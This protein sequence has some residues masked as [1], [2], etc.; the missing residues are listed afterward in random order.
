MKSLIYEAFGENS[1]ALLGPTGVSALNINGSTIHSKLHI[2]PKTKKML[3]LQAGALHDFRRKFEKTLFVLID[4]YSMIGCA[5]LDKIEK[6]LR[7]A[8]DKKNEPYGG[9]FLYFFGDVQQLAPVGD[10]PVYS[11]NQESPDYING[12]LLYNNIDSSIVLSQVQRQNNADFQDLLHNVSTGAVTKKDYKLLKRRFVTSVSASEKQSFDNVIHLYSTRKEVY[13]HN[14]DKLENLKD[15]VTGSPVPVAKIPAL[16]NCE[17]AAHATENEADGLKSVLYLAVGAKVMLKANL[18]TEQACIC[19]TSN[20]YSTPPIH[21]NYINV[22]LQGL[23]NGAIGQIVDI[24]YDKDSSPGEDP[25]SAIVC[26]LPSYKGPYLN[27]A[28]K[29]VV[30]QPITKSWKDKKGQDCTR[31]QFPLV[32]SYACTI[33]KSQGLTLEKVI[34]KTPNNDYKFQYALKVFIQHHPS[35]SFLL[36]PFRLS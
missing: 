8:L 17:A 30:I 33:H 35:M 28:D 5:M 11:N 31:I 13:D 12:K 27:E 26:Q 29:T 1:F 9:L 21:S 3:P 36:P 19:C 16:H 32:L 24:L 2:Q 25:P 34:K 7:E 15:A 18:W 14:I 10:S 22:H 20:K 4:E 6:R 23:V